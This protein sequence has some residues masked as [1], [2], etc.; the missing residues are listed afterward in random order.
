MRYLQERLKKEQATN[1]QTKKKSN[2]NYE[3]RETLQT[4]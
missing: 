1:K 2:D 3:T 4:N